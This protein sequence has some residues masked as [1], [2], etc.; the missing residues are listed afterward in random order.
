[1]AL[2]IDYSLW[3]DIGQ[4]LGIEDY[5]LNTIKADNARKPHH[6]V[7]CMVNMFSLWIQMESQPTYKKVAVA[8]SAVGMREIGILL[9]EKYGMLPNV[10]V[11]ICMTITSNLKVNEVPY[12][13]V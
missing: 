1:M 12:V 2:Q 11:F 10:I 4:E 8:L 13:G 7:D 5:K 3:Y 9:C 6:S